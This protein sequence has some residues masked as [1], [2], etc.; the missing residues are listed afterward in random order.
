[1]SPPCWPSA[2]ARSS[3]S[4][5]CS[6]SPM[7]A[8][9]CWRPTCTP[10]SPSTQGWSVGR[11][12]AGHRRHREPARHAGASC[13]CCAGWQTA[14]FI[15]KVIVTLGLL[16]PHAGRR[17]AA[18]RL[19]PEEGPAAVQRRDRHR[20][21]GGRQPADRHPG[22]RRSALMAGLRCSCGAPASV[23]PPAPAPRTGTV[24]GLIGIPTRV[25]S[26]VNWTIGAFMAAV[27]GV[28]IAPLAVFTVDSFSIYL[29]TGI[30]AA[31]FGGLTGLTGA[32]VGRPRP[33][34]GPELGHRRIVAAGHLGAGHL[35]GHRRRCCSCRRRWPKEL[36]ATAT[37]SGGTGGWRRQH[38]AG[39]PARP[40]PPAGGCSCSTP[41][42]PTSG[43]T[44]RRWSC[45]TC[46]SPCRSWS[47]GGWTG[48][49]SL[50]QGALVG[51]GRVHACWR[52]ATTTAS[53]FFPALLAITLAVGR[54]RRP[55]CSAL[56]SL[57]LS[58]T[59]VAIAT[60]ARRWWPASG[61]SP[62]A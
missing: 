47:A 10:G 26:S 2:S 29:V 22:R 1:M 38:L 24:A 40:S 14:P 39:G 61:C 58:S 34:R 37:V 36:L 53:T 15:T 7:P 25:V 60:L 57:R 11:G 44:P 54:L 31:L 18:L 62:R 49:L 33:R 41:S 52:C 23:W 32:F 16:R 19:R 5:A 46:W 45:S 56:L 43:P 50:G 59:Q 27:A 48:Q 35:R 28:L 30:G 13:W 21:H 55:A 17:P 4:P 8:S 6:T 51:V 12:R 3:R 20:R 42:G 9:P